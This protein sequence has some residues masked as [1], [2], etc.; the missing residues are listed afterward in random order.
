MGAGQVLAHLVVERE[1]G[2]S[3]AVLMA[4]ASFVCFMG[5]VS[6]RRYP[7]AR[8]TL[9]SDAAEMLQG[10]VSKDVPS[11]PILHSM[12]SNSLLPRRGYKK[13]I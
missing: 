1:S 8:P 3:A 2:T 11:L 6:S 5:A 13:L 10:G 7:S 9:A 4:M 12:G